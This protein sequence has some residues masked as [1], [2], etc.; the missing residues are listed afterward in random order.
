MAIINNLVMHING[1]NTVVYPNT[2]GEAVYMNILNRYTLPQA[3]N[4]LRNNSVS[5]WEDISNKPFTTLKP[6]DFIVVDGQ[7]RLAGSF[8]AE[9]DS[10]ANKPAVFPTSWSRISG[11]PGSFPTTWEDIEGIPSYMPS[12]WENIYNKPSY[13]NTQWE[14]IDNKPEYF[15]AEWFY[16]NNKPFNYVE[17]KYFNIQDETLKFSDNN[18][19]KVELLNEDLGKNTFLT[20]NIYQGNNENSNNQ[21]LLNVNIPY[22][23]YLNAGIYGDINKIGIQIGNS[24][25]YYNK[26][27]Y[28]AA[29]TPEYTIMPNVVHPDY[30]INFFQNMS[31][32]S[33][34]SAWSLNFAP[35]TGSWRDS[36]LT[37]FNIALINNCSYLFDRIERVGQ[38]YY[39]SNIV[40]VVINNVAFPQAY[41]FKHFI[42]Y[43]NPN[44]F[45]SNN[46]FNLIFE[47]DF[48]NI[49]RY[50]YEVINQG[51]FVR[52]VYFTNFKGNG[53]FARI[54]NI[55][56]NPNDPYYRSLDYYFDNVLFYFSG[57]EGY[58]FSN[59]FDDHHKQLHITNDSCADGYYYYDNNNAMVTKYRML[60]GLFPVDNISFNNTSRYGMW[61][62]LFSCIT[63][64]YYPWNV[65]GVNIR[66]DNCGWT[67]DHTSFRC[68]YSNERGYLNGAR[69]WFNNMFIYNRYDNFI[70]RYYSPRYGGYSNFTLMSSNV[71]IF[72][73]QAE[74]L[75]NFYYDSPALFY[76]V[77]CN[78]DVNFYIK[79]LIYTRPRSGGDENYYGF[80]VLSITNNSQIN[81][82]NYYFENINFGD[83]KPN[84]ADI[85]NNINIYFNNCKMNNIQLG[86][87]T[88]NHHI[89]RINVDG[90]G[91]ELINNLVYFGNVD[92]T[93][94]N[95]NTPLI[96]G[97]V[98]IYRSSYYDNNSSTTTI[99]MPIE[100]MS[101]GFSYG[102]FNYKLKSHKKYIYI[103]GDTAL[104]RQ[105][106]NVNN[107][108]KNIF[109][110][111]AANI[112]EDFIKTTITNG[113]SIPN[114]NLFI[115][116]QNYISNH[117]Y[118]SVD[119]YPAS[120]VPIENFNVTDIA[121]TILYEGELVPNENI[122]FV[123]NEWSTKK[124]NSY[125]NKEDNA[126][127]LCIPD[128]NTLFLPSST[129]VQGFMVGTNYT[130]KNVYNQAKKLPKMSY[131]VSG[132]QTLTEGLNWE[133]ATELVSLYGGCSNLISANL[134]S[135]AINIDSAF[136]GCPNFTTLPSIPASVLYMNYTFSGCS[137]LT[138]TPILPPNV[139]EA[140]MTFGGC[141]NLTGT[142]VIAGDNTNLQ[143]T[144]SGCVNLNGSV[145][146]PKVK[147]M[148]SPFY[149]TK[150]E[151][152]YLEGIS[153]YSNS[154][155]S[156]LYAGMDYLRRLA[157]VA[158]I[159]S[160]SYGSDQAYKLN[161][162][163]YFKVL[164]NDIPNVVSYTA[165]YGLN[166]NCIKLV[167]P[168]VFNQVS[169]NSGY[170]GNYGPNMVISAGGGINGINN[171]SSVYT[172]VG[173]GAYVQNITVYGK[174]N[175]YYAYDSRTYGN[176]TAMT[177]L[178]LDGY[179]E[180]LSSA[181]SQG[182]YLFAPQTLVFG[183][184]P[185]KSVEDTNYSYFNVN[186]YVG[187]TS[188]LLVPTL[189]DDYNNFSMS[190]ITGGYSGCS[191]LVYIV[192]PSGKYSRGQS[193]GMGFYS[194][195][196]GG[197]SNLKY[198]IA[199]TYAPIVNVYGSF[200]GC[201]NLTKFF[202]KVINVY[203][204]FGGDSNLTLENYY[205]Q[206]IEYSFNGACK[207]TVSTN[208]LM[209]NIRSS[210]SGSGVSEVNV[211]ICTIYD[212]FGGSSNL[213]NVILNMQ[214][215]NS[216]SL[217]WENNA[218]LY[219]SFIGCSKLKYVNIS[220]T[221][222][223]TSD[224]HFLGGNCF[225]GCPNLE[226]VDV[227]RVSLPN[228][229]SFN[230]QD[231]YG[232]N[233]P[234][235]AK[236][237]TLK[238]YDLP[239]SPSISFRFCANCQ[240]LQNFEILAD[241]NNTT[242]FAMAFENCYN[243]TT[244]N[245]FGA[246]LNNVW[247]CFR[248][249]FNLTECYSG[250]NV[251]D[252]AFCYSGC[253]NIR[254]AN[255]GPLVENLFGAFQGCVN[256]NKNIY[257][258][259]PYINT[260]SGICQMLEGDS[261][262]RYNIYVIGNSNTNASFYSLEGMVYSFL[263]TNNNN[264]DEHPNIHWEMDYANSCYYDTNSNIY[265][266]YTLNQEDN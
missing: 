217:S 73:N 34:S 165:E 100:S 147:Y 182:I 64:I 52:G 199:G 70:S 16:V 101:T 43:I 81:N 3:L 33:T 227:S 261:S 142:P 123:S 6:S 22:I 145:T 194:G 210:F 239:M 85:G 132:D 51:E 83:L 211:I 111:S 215:W 116:N 96:N 168:P 18:L 44:G 223:S 186:G 129:G 68:F 218:N 226:Y 192:G 71:N 54:V 53:N 67:T 77:Y 37:C 228:N 174:G 89:N 242:Q 180:K 97:Y 134:P 243:L 222:A 115:Y 13:Y 46:T 195:V 159:L 149:G 126:L 40:N 108:A 110:L 95:M 4:D 42:N 196:G 14:L 65:E 214:D 1:E 55:T 69:V 74:P 204:S 139:I 203:N 118:L 252:M 166:Y 191:N 208:Q 251:R 32:E 209:H 236:L 169:V 190:A 17:N 26:G 241:Y 104:D 170:N 2:L 266:Y 245:Y 61:S 92:T 99:Y 109:N 259:T 80:R 50:F 258:N 146:I 171:G 262:N 220:Y 253:R 49:G 187:S 175:Y 232:C 131:S 185:Y 93:Y 244:M 263:F 160:N 11:K 207:G 172:S 31:F 41:N 21:S 112:P 181:S 19:I 30:A 27:I 216:S 247:A 87:N 63:D 25:Y 122:I 24:T 254:T 221:T 156:N 106:Q 90:D 155:G 231:S 62:Y 260:N 152:L 15:N 91:Y 48:R 151:E 128:I 144:F 9:W 237:H 164:N 240:N 143:N 8:T 173:N 82:V 248:N 137:K 78:H 212:S 75:M 176:F 249:C 206:Q 29:M 119:S 179:S 238:M 138:G 125:F 103:L 86:G 102:L 219:N 5:R 133:G 105:W 197:C 230:N 130:Y 193:Y 117:T 224:H 184:L 107:I 36:A 124:Y 121:D 114:Y 233:F 76:N 84:V 235:A 47:G 202:G 264:I 94:L 135:T 154:Y 140:N 229:A 10:I 60:L 28:S 58:L 7:L 213:V 183:V 88:E 200:G 79:G 255:I 59:Q 265:V 38:T 12:K 163:E 153:P 161:N 201:S 136:G 45:N 178:V 158:P 120:N 56:R 198:I 66:F 150:I 250:P 141:S 205:M 162:L 256:L 148:I 157:V 177:N 127:Y 39:L 257:I 20:E 189:L 167:Y 35:A 246:R 234:E 98:N 57:N 188:N 72:I 225:S 23:T 113:F